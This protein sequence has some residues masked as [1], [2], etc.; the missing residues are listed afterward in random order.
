MLKKIINIILIILLVLFQ[1]SFINTQRFPLNQIDMLL[2]FL[3]LLVS[4]NSKYSIY[5]LVFVSLILELYS[6]YPFGL[7]FLSFVLTF[8]LIRWISI[9]FFTNKSFYSSS[10]IFVIAITFFNLVLNGINE[11]FYHMHLSF[12]SF[13]QNS[14]YLSIF[15]AKIFLNLIIF[16]IVSIFYKILRKKMSTVFILE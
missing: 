9:D 10:M 12:F 6:N 15:M 11:I 14:E 2:I 7:I 1:V 3:V 16:I 5:F 8:F 13:F 4:N